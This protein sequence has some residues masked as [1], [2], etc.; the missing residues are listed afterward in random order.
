MVP[1]PL[2]GVRYCGAS[3]IDDVGERGVN[4][5]GTSYDVITRDAIIIQPSPRHVRDMLQLF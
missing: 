2:V 5:H 3:D 1:Y 4:E